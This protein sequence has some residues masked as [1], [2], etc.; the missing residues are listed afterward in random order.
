MIHEILKE[1]KLYHKGKLASVN[2]QLLVKTK[3]SNVYITLLPPLSLT[4]SLSQVFCDFGGNFKLSDIM[5]NNLF[6]S[7]S[8]LSPGRRTPCCHIWMRPDTPCSLKIMSPSV[9]YRWADMAN[10]GWSTVELLLLNTYRTI[11][12]PVV[13]SM[14]HVRIL[15][16]HAVTRIYAC[17][18]TVVTPPVCDMR[19][20][21]QY[22]SYEIL[23]GKST[24]TLSSNWL[25]HYAQ[26][27][28]AHTNYHEGSI[29]YFWVKPF[30]AVVRSVR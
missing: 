2:N 12:T 17:A 3:R 14:N 6:L 28:I 13:T 29:H 7:S 20:F 4:L 24:A 15:L 9:K 11:V 18:N 23:P 27:G 10:L 16:S 21:T 1:V 22:L 19:L 5:E 30:T 8:H 26:Q 25:L